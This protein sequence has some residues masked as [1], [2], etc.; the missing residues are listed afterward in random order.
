MNKVAE[1]ERQIDKKRWNKWSE[2]TARGENMREQDISMMID[3]DWRNKGNIRKINEKNF[4][5]NGIR[6]RE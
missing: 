1:V 2:I 4:E 6:L 3:A 5:E